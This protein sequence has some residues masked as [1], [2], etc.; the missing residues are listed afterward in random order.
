M[1]VIQKGCRDKAWIMKHH[2]EPQQRL[3]QNSEN[4]SVD[5]EPKHCKDIFSATTWGI[6]NEGKMGGLVRKV[7]KNKQDYK[8]YHTREN[9]RGWA[10]NISLY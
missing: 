8:N 5:V 4:A 2:R 3:P 9:Q 6:V 7:K 10:S 1:N